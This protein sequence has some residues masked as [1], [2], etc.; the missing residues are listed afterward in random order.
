MYSIRQA[1][2]EMEQARVHLSEAVD[3]ARA[4]GCSW[5]QIGKELNMTRQAA[6]K[7]FGKPHNPRTHQRL[8]PR[9]VDEACQLTEQ[10]FQKM[11]S[12]DYE[13][14]SA[15]MDEP[16]RSQITAEELEKL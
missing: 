2:Q 5:A 4:D 14:I 12:G 15:M 7:R 11:A 3:Q 9:S 8:V 6:F 13:S 1:Q 10:I 16:A